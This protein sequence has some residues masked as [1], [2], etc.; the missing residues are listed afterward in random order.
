[1]TLAGGLVG[2]RVACASSNMTSIYLYDYCLLEIVEGTG[3]NLR[4]QT[5]MHVLLALRL[6]NEEEDY[7]GLDGLRLLLCATWYVPSG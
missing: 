1:M 3:F 2:C 6:H 4:P 5:F 7:P